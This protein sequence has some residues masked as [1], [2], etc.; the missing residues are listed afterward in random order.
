MKNMFKGKHVHKEF[1]GFTLIEMLVVLFVIS[2]LVLLFVPNLASQRVKIEDQGKVA[3]E[4]VIKTQVELF[5]MNETIEVSYD[6]LVKEHYLTKSQAD[7][8]ISWHIS[9]DDDT[10]E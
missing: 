2:V 6:N 1:D 7:K 9:L 8:A 3:F 5:E 4:K 10:G